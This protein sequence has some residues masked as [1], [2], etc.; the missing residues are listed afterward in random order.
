MN[1]SYSV[2]FCRETWIDFQEYLHIH[3]D[4][5]NNINDSSNPYFPVVEL[6]VAGTFLTEND[7]PLINKINSIF[8]LRSYSTVNSITKLLVRCNMI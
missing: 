1:F 5:K 6:S 8:N 4:S 3:Q 2:F 7:E